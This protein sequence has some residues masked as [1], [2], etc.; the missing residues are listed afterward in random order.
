MSVEHARD[1]TPSEGPAPATRPH[2]ASPVR[3]E[4][5]RA[6]AQ[7]RARLH[8][9]FDF[10]A[11][12]V[13]PFRMQPGLRRLPA[14]AT[15]LTPLAPGSR[16]QREKLAVLCAF[17]R[18]ALVQT[19]DFDA[20]PAWAAV[21]AQAAAEHPEH[22]QWD[23]ARAAAPRLGVAVA[24]GAVVDLGRGAFGLGDEIGRCLRGL[25]G[26]WR[27]AGLFALTFLEDLAIVDGASGTVPWM[28]VTLPS[29]WAPEDKVGLHFGAIHGPVADNRLLLDAG[30]ALM[31]MVCGGERWERFVWTVTDHPRLHAHPQRLDPQRWPAGAATVLPGQAWW[32]TERQTFL[33]VPAAGQ[34]VFTIAVDVQALAS[35]IDD[36]GRA[37]A[38]RDAVETM[39]DEVL[40]YRGL[41][42]VRAALL[43]WLE[44]QAG[45]GPDRPFLPAALAPET[46]PP[47]AQP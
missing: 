10:E 9:G 38:L 14:G 26:P 41:A 43:A 44:R 17:W 32:R 8:N 16:A 25:P 37:R 6:H 24:D 30:P 15:Q 31:R 45:A 11:A 1:R 12:V 28:A 46:A 13:A 27:L 23:G 29:H 4:F 2:D 40:G 3:P 21:A 34:A 20:A 22:W 7:G 5:P 42:P 47:A 39:S 33:P 19:P 36:P 18:Q 35:A